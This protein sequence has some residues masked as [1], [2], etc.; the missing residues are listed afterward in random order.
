MTTINRDRLIDELQADAVRVEQ[1]LRALTPTR[2]A[3]GAYEQG[4]TVKDVVAHLAS[5]EWT[6]ARLFD[7]PTTSSETHAGDADSGTN[8]SSAVDM[9]AYNA[10]QVDKRRNAT[11]DALLTEFRRNRERTIAAVRGATDAELARRI[12]SLGG[13][14][15]RLADVIQRVAVEHVRVHLRDIEDARSS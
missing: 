5:I 10:R 11:V 1:V 2:L 4:W 8:S 7:L 12:T 3:S 14:S 13:A 9:N 6:Y 15:G